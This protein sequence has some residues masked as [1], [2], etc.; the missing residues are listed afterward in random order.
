MPDVDRLRLRDRK[1]I[2]DEPLE[3]QADRFGDEL[4]GIFV[5]GARDADAWQG[6]H[7]GAPPSRRSLVDDGPGAQRAFLDKPACRKML[8]SVPSATSRPR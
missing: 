3:V 8:P 2:L 5:R 1:A 7:V 6:G 4:F